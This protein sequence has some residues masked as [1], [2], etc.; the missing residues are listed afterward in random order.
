MALNEELRSMLL[1]FK[2]SASIDIRGGSPDN[3]PWVRGEIS[4]K[5]PILYGPVDLLAPL[6]YKNV[7][8]WYLDFIQNA[9]CRTIKVYFPGV[10]FAIEAKYR[11]NGHNF[12][13]A[14][15]P[16]ISGEETSRERSH[17][18]SLIY[19]HGEPSELSRLILSRLSLDKLD[20]LYLHT[21]VPFNITMRELVL[22]HYNLTEN[23]D[24]A[25][26]LFPTMK[27]NWHDVLSYLENPKQKEPYYSPPIISK[28]IRMNYLASTLFGFGESSSK[29][30]PRMKIPRIKLEK[31][32]QR[33]LENAISYGNLSMATLIYAD[34]IYQELIS[35][36]NP[37]ISNDVN[38]LA[39]LNSILYVLLLDLVNASPSIPSDPE[40]YMFILNLL[41]IGQSKPLKTSYQQFCK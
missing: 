24:N 21:S 40:S 19:F 37:K 10:P 32:L 6:G 36:P 38:Y 30:P 17:L 22:S 2:M 4:F 18:P 39:P 34:P 14:F 23:S 41:G 16:I 7:S 15:S 12:D 35:G 5:D 25:A 29:S 9:I 13:F 33:H 3:F 28:Y 26:K 27:I 31:E 20:H 1:K 11:D 8:S